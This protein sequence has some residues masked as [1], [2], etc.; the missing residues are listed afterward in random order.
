MRRR[1]RVLG[2]LGAGERK[3]RAAQHLGT[4][5]T[6]RLL[7]RM[8]VNEAAQRHEEGFSLWRSPGTAFIG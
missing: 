6:L 4:Q 1:A 5:G 2:G 7:V 8:G 3:A